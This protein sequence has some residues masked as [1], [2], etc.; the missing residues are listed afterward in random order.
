MTQIQKPPKNMDSVV[1]NYL[2]QLAERLNLTLGGMR[3]EIKEA[4]NAVQ[5]MRQISGKGGG[6]LS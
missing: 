1:Y 4:D 6:S 3:A 2:Y 5:E